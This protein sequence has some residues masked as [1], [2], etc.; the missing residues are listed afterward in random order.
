MSRRRSL[1][2]LLYLSDDGWDEP[3]GSGSGGTLRAF[4]RRDAVGVCG[5]HGGC[6]QVGW[7]ERGRGAEAVFLDSWVVPAWMAGRSLTELRREWSE[8]L[9]DEGE[10]WTALYK[11]QPSYVLFC[12]DADGARE[13]LGERVDAPRRDEAGAPLDGPPPSLREML[14]EELRDGFSST[15]CYHPMQSPPL[16]VSPR[17]GTLVLFDTLA[18]PHEVDAVV[19]G[20]RLLLFGFFAEERPIPEA[21]RDHA[22]SVCGD[23]FPDGWA[24]MDDMQ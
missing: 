23:W 9:A 16:E 22:Q 4:P 18:V 17:G 10:L 8:E 3:G 1:G 12:V 5:A 24:H 2:W 21:W 7:L 19:A 11:V 20:E 15:V 13:E 14:P 6:Q